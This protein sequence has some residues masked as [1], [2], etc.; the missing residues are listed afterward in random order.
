[1]SLPTRGL[2]GFG[3]GSDILLGEG[4]RWRL[5]W[6]EAS[7]ERLRRYGKSVSVEVEVEDYCTVQ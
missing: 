6:I 2:G 1:M 3:P 5:S 7:G 4:R